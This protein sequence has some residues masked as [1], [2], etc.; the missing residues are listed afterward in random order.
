MAIPEYKNGHFLA[1]MSL[2]VISFWHFLTLKTDQWYV[3]WVKESSK[4]AGLQ[5][6]FWNS[7]V[8]KKLNIIQWFAMI[9]LEQDMF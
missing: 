7:L 6:V 3:L 4:C 5:K 2:C 1:L 8:S 9:G